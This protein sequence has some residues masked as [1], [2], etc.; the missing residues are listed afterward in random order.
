M[1]CLDDLKILLY[2]NDYSEALVREKINIFLRSKEKPKLPDFDAYL[3]LNYTSPQTE[4]HAR[5]LLSKMKLFLPDFNVSLC[6]QTIKL[7]KL[8]SQSAKAD[9]EPIIE[10]ANTN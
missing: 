3:C 1:A 6:L 8:F 2:R 10:T 9:P 4:Y 5:K 7:S